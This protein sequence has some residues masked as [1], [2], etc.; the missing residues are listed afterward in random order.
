VSVG[1]AGGGAK[2]RPGGEFQTLAVGQI[3]PPLIPDAGAAE[4]ELAVGFN[5]I[6]AFAADFVEPVF[7]GIHGSFKFADFLG[8]NVQVVN[9][10]EQI[11]EALEIFDPGG[12]VLGEESFDRV[13]EFLQ[14]DAKSVPGFRFFGTQRAVMQVLGFVEAFEGE[15][16]GTKAT[17]GNETNAAPKRTV[18]AKPATLVELSRNAKR[19]FSAFLFA[20]L[21]RGE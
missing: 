19:G 11:L 4:S 13:A 6:V 17:D 14:A 21:P 9:V 10:A 7:D 12:G 16:F 2:T 8:E 3:V 18:E 5:A 1:G 20:G 15:A